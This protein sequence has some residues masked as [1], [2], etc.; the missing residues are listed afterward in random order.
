MARSLGCSPETVIGPRRHIYARED[1]QYELADFANCFAVV[2]CLS[3][4]L[5]IPPACTE[6]S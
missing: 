2:G 3:N 4:D 6:S 1:T 5:K